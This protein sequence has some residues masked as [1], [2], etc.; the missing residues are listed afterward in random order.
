MGTGARCGCWNTSRFQNTLLFHHPENER[1]VA[2]PDGLWTAHDRSHWTADGEIYLA[3]CKTSLHPPPSRPDK[4]PVRYKRQMW[5]EQYVMGATRTA[6]VWEQHV[7]F[8]PVFMEP[9]L[10]WFDR[11]DEAIDRLVTIANYV[12]DGFDDAAAFANDMK[13]TPR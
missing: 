2:T 11:N 9:S 3:Q 8:R 7:D 12:L 4:I 13:G 10:I 5:W 6:L 1:H